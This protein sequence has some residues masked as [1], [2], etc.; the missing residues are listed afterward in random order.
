MPFLIAFIIAVLLE[1]IIRKIHK[2]TNLTR[3]TVAIIV[4]VIA[5]SIIVGFLLW[6]IAVLIDEGSNF[7][8]SLNIYI[9]EGYK[10]ITGY[11]DRL[12]FNEMR[13]SRELD[14][15]IKN[16][17]SNLLN[18]ISAWVSS[19]LTNAITWLTSI[20]SI[21]IY[22]VITIIATYFIC[23]DRLYI[24]DQIEHHFPKE[25]VKKFSKNIKKIITSLGG[26]L[27]AEAILV[28]IDFVLILI[29]TNYI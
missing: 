2:R 22:I 29:R 14:T 25:W 23:V 20:G 21:G 5:F 17:T 27:K 4:L 1:P 19:F 3:K 26:Y 16:S 18:N 12:N 13:I 28:A 11:I 15:I 7:L 9:D 24:L 8:S 10:F 6:G